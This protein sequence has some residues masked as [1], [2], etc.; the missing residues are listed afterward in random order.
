MADGKGTLG[1]M[2][3]D[4]KPLLSICIP[5]FNRCNALNKTLHSICE[6]DLFQN[7][8]IC[9]LIISDNCSTDNTKLICER[10]VNR[11]PNK[12]KYILQN[13][14]IPADI[15]IFKSISYA[16]GI[17]TKLHND[18]LVFLPDKFEKMVNL[19][20]NTGTQHVIFFTNGNKTKFNEGLIVNSSDEFLDK[21]SFF[22]TWIGGF[23][24]QNGLLETLDNPY[25][26]SNLK[27]QQVDILLR[28]VNSENN[29]IIFKEKLFNPLMFKSHGKSYN[30]AEIFGKNFLQ[31]LKSDMKLCHISKLTYDK[32][33]K[34]ILVNQINPRYF[35][36]AN[37]LNFNK[38]G[39]FKY[40]FDDYKSNYYFY[41]ELIKQPI[42]ICGVILQKFFN[43]LK[44]NMFN[45]KWR[46]QNKHNFTILKEKIDFNKIFIGKNT[47]GI[48]DVKFDKNNSC[49]FL[50]IGNNCKIEDNVKFR[51]TGND[52][53]IIPDNTIL[54]SGSI[55]TKTREIINV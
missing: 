53:I 30:I 36:W 37:E 51:F 4:E 10:F 40:L 26:F 25:R 18:T 1:K 44:Q 12:I 45:R 52:E 19:L 16:D 22:T 38:T 48:I 43:I 49:N 46:K 3:V 17:Y 50:Y 54:K 9:Q 55:V 35:D 42:L 33:K 14:A 8:N 24:I 6:T 5:T 23:C 34:D 47:T 21:V 31:I 13:P 28:L 27:L 2:V 7:T 39:Y 20:K 15:N 29:A 41:F 32:V 11:F